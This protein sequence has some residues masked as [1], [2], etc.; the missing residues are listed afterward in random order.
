MR[1]LYCGEP[2]AK[3]PQDAASAFC[4]IGHR[5]M[6]QWNRASTGNGAAGSRTIAQLVAAAEAGETGNDVLGP[7]RWRRREPLA[8]ELPART[9]ETEAAALLTEA[10]APE[11]DLACSLG[12]Y[13]CDEVPWTATPALGPHK[14]RIPRAT[15]IA[16]F[17]ANRW[18]PSRSIERTA[19][20]PLC[21]G[22]ALARLLD[23]GKRL[24]HSKGERP[25][26][27]VT[28]AILG[29]L[30]ANLSVTEM[31]PM[32]PIVENLRQ[33]A[34][35]A[36]KLAPGPDDPPS[37]ILMMLAS[38]APATRP[39]K[40]RLGKA[41]RE[42]APWAAKVIDLR[43]TGRRLLESQSDQSWFPGVEAW[44]PDYVR[45][46]VTPRP[47]A[48]MGEWKRVPRAFPA[49]DTRTQTAAAVPVSRLAQ[50]DAALRRYAE[51]IAIEFVCPP[52]DSPVAPSLLIEPAFESEQAQTGPSVPQSR[53]ALERPSLGASF[54]VAG[55][56][57]AV[58][59]PPAALL[60]ADT[61]LL[62]QQEH[63]DPAWPEFRGAPD[64]IRGEI[65]AAASLY[66]IQAA[67]NQAPPAA[68][69]SSAPEF[70]QMEMEAP[71]TQKPAFGWRRELAPPLAKA[72]SRLS[73]Q[74]AMPFAG[75]SFTRGDVAPMNAEGMRVIPGLKAKLI[76]DKRVAEAVQHYNETVGRGWVQKITS[77]FRKPEKSAPPVSTAK[78]IKAGSRNGPAN[79]KWVLIA[80]VPAA[81]A[82]AF[83]LLKPGAA[84]V[85]GASAEAPVEIAQQVPAPTK[86]AAATATPAASRTKQRRQ[87][88][89]KQEPP[90]IQQVSNDAGQPRDF[91]GQVKQAILKRAAVNLS[92]DF[93][94]GLGDWQ[95]YGE[96]S[97]QWSYDAATFLNTGPSVVL[98]TPS[99][100]LSNYRM[101]FL[102]QIEK[103]SLGWVF[104]AKDATN[105]HAAKITLTHGGP[106]PRAIVEHYAVING[107]EER[108]QSRPLPLEIRTDTLYRVSMDI[109]DENFTL[110]VQGQIVDHW[111]DNRL[112]SGGV[113]FFSARGEQSRLRWVE[114]SHQY[115]MLG[116]LCAFLAPYSLP[117]REGN[118]K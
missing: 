97:K 37:S 3:P 102:G 114:V 25:L 44:R 2:L 109:Q 104:R 40:P 105:Y 85:P 15:G 9:V 39:P 8:S 101:D 63:F 67:A 24:A 103:R 72:Q 78:G 45:A 47:A 80:A 70:I 31:D 11:S 66:A 71:E 18:L 5:Q 55:S 111:S 46:I 35:A 87:T 34:A 54:L 65:G 79:L 112:P 68:R 110:S 61:E 48:G 77:A 14:P 82:S 51:R 81:L 6:Y 86:Q 94:S 38:H 57:P 13:E 52:L 93:R 29:R 74:Q 69:I 117:A 84:S 49:L 98:Y 53:P 75:A 92:D 116:K 7:F 50:R 108:R 4:S 59:A 95:G 36:A 100:G 83:F 33:K 89:A 62:P 21:P 30:R 88:P 17:P 91:F 64:A 90:A 23:G 115:D 10:Y 56:A 12:F 118:T 19:S 76:Q 41:Q 42:T 22:T 32:P 107:R 1:C 27:F 106:L 16:V 43:D 58:I 113:G 20:M 26:K 73:P 99:L 60:G 96:W 28:K